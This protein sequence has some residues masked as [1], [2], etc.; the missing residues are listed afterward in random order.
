MIRMKG[1]FTLEIPEEL[2]DAIR[3]P[4]EEIPGRL[5]RELAVRLYDKGLLSFGKARE[6]AEMTRW[7]FHDLLYEEGIIRHY[8]VE[9]L[10]E[11]I[12][13]LEKLD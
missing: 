8:D 6:L 10:E 4:A 13:T 11:D 5:K 12:A 9:E 7:E 3:L 2:T 1:T